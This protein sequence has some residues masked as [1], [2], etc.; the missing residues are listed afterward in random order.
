MV[1]ILYRT[2][3]ETLVDTDSGITKVGKAFTQRV[4]APPKPKK[5]KPTKP[6]KQF[7]PSVSSN[8]GEVEM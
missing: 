6:T 8:E 1:Q 7:I 3:I 5:P 4:G 2:I